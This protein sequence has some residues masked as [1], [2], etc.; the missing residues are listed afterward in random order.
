DAVPRKRELDV[1]VRDALDRLDRPGDLALERPLVV[2]LLLEVRGAE[3]LLVEELEADVA[4]V[5]KPLLGER[6]A[7]RR[8]L[9]LDDVDL[10]TAFRELPADAARVEGVA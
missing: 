2:H 4:A 8:L 3:A 6:D 7:G 1:G 9:P 10:G 5:R